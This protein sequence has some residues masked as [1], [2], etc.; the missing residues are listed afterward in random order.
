MRALLITL[1]GV[2][3]VEMGAEVERA[4]ALLQNRPFNKETANL[5]SMYRLMDCQTIT[6]AG[7]PDSHHACWADDEALLTLQDGNQVTVA[8]WYPEKLIG[9]LLITGFNPLTGATTPASLTVEEVESMVKIG[10]VRML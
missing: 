5:Q 8:S 10:E 1:D 3:E 2:Q 9:K 6:G 4:Q 7:Y